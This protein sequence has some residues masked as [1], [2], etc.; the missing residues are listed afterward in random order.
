M[1]LIR[2]YPQWFESIWEAYPKFPKGRSLKADAFEACETKR[3]EDNWESKDI[4]QLIKI[5]MGFKKNAPHWQETNQYGPPSLQSFIRR[6]LY[7]N[8][9]P[10]TH[11]PKRKLDRFDRANIEFE[12]R[13]RSVK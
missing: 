8:E 9:I 6:R 7:E 2:D 10:E 11:V 5:I 4:S 1:G 3:I 12:N 13:L